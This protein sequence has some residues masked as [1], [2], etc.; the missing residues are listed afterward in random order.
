MASKHTLEGLMKWSMRDHW[1]DRFE[2]TLED[3]LITT[4]DETGLEID[5]I[6]TLIGE[7][8]LARCGPALS[9]TS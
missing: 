7:N 1:A 6:V 8:L 9:K 3:H 4:C 5:D 2:Q